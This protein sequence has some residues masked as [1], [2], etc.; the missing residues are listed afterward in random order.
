M[1]AGMRWDLFG[2]LVDHHGDV[3]FGWRLAA[4]LAARGVEVRYWLDDRADLTWM[5]PHGAPGVRVGGWDQAGRI[6]PADVVVETFGCGLPDA[7]L[8]R[9]AARASPP[10]WLDVEHLS[11]EDYVERSHG[12]PSP[13]THGPGAGLAMRYVY[14]GFTAA[15]A[16]RRDRAAT[17][18]PRRRTRRVAR[19]DPARAAGPRWPP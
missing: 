1:I 5:A 2:R 18:R 11:A 17:T 13:R 6:E 19:G 4:D 16:C 3:G 14:P 8:A 9:M 7:F 15:A 12:L 10:P